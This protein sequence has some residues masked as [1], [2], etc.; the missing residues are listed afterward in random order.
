MTASNDYFL[1]DSAPPPQRPIAPEAGT[2]FGDAFHVTETLGHGEHS[3][4]VA[5]TVSQAQEVAALRVVRGG[6]W[7][8]E[9]DLEGPLPVTEVE[10]GHHEHVLPVFQRHMQREHGCRL[11]IDVMAFA[12]GGSV[13]SWLAHSGDVEPEQRRIEA[14]LYVRQAIQGLL[15]FE[16][17]G[18]ALPPLKWSN[19]L[20]IDG[21]LKVAPPSRWALGIPEGRESRKTRCERIHQLGLLYYAIL[22]PQRQVPAMDRRGRVKDS[23]QAVAG[24]DIERA[25]LSKALTVGRHEGFDSL[26]AMDRALDQ[27]GFQLRCEPSEQVLNTWH[28]AAGLYLA[29]KT[30]QARE[31]LSQ[32]DRMSDEFGLLNALEQALES[33]TNEAETAIEA[34][35]SE[36]HAPAQQRINRLR[37]AA[38]LDPDH[39]RLEQ[40]QATVGQTVSELETTAKEGYRLWREGHITAA[41][42]QLRAA[43][44]MAPADEQLQAAYQRAEQLAQWASER[45]AAYEQAMADWRWGDAAGIHA[46]LKEAGIAE[47]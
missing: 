9:H 12:N 37:R 23:A 3:A 34:A 33:A 31:T 17:H 40:A 43:A 44:A 21:A 28:E 26:Q 29:G 14:V 27:A 41:R 10:R 2:D 47:A 18:L 15:A 1:C 7:R 13:A 46:R 5:V 39:P 24:N 36:H 8:F 25:I 30:Q 38:Q 19:L 42:D 45:W 20:F 11:V 32:A 4:V 16:Q 6:G 22:H 35:E